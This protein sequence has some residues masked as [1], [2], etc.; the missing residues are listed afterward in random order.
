MTFILLLFSSVV[1]KIDQ[2][3]KGSKSWNA[4]AKLIDLKIFIQSYYSR[5]KLKD[6]CY[7]RCSN[8]V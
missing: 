6:R 3:H 5:K 2:T 4:L 8:V 1:G 7:S